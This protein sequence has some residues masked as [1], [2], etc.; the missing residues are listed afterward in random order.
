[1]LRIHRGA[2]G[3]ELRG[4]TLCFIVFWVLSSQACLCYVVRV[5]L[6]ER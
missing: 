6:S 3:L 4:K 5:L 1:M 2:R